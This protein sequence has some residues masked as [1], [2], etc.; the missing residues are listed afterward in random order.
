MLTRYTHIFILFLL[1]SLVIPNAAALGSQ[2]FFKNSF[3]NLKTD[4]TEAAKVGRIL[5]VIYEQEGCV[6]CAEMHKVNFADK[7]TVDILTKHFDVVQLDIWG[8]REVADFAG[9]TLTEKQLARNLKIQLSPMINFFGPDGKE[10]FRI[11]G[12]YKPQL[13]KTALRYVAEGRYAQTSFRDYALKYAPE[14]VK[15]GLIDEPLFTKTTDL[16]LAAAQAGA[17][18]KGVALLF[19]QAQCASCV[20]LH[21]KTF[22]DERAVRKLTKKFDVVRVDLWGK[23]TILGL[24]GKN[25]TESE[26]GQALEVRYTPTIIFYDKT[27]NEIFRYESYRKPEH[28]LVLLT[29]LTTDGYVK[30]K[31][32]QDWLRAEDPAHAALEPRKTGQR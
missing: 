26:L 3:L 14:P 5:M 7:E 30:Y 11:A 4:L 31:S 17:K 21:E 18:N 1:S 16:K 25:V 28:F 13:F 15:K 2:P 9:N 29:Y 32:F 27:S 22:S 12:Y 6:Y 10:V 20:E 19:E 8:G 24:D 23:R